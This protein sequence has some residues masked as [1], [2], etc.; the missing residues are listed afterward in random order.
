VPIIIHRERTLGQ[1]ASLV[2]GM[3]VIDPAGLEKLRK[4]LRAF[5]KQLADPDVAANA[6]EVAKRLG[7]FELNADAFV[8]ALSAPVKA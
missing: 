4:N 1:G 2:A 8:N 5:A 6:S 7:Q 3:R